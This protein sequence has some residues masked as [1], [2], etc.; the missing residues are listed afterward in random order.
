MVC[1]LNSF[2]VQYEFL[3]QNQGTQ[4]SPVLKNIWFFSLFCLSSAIKFSFF[5]HVFLLPLPVDQDECSAEDHNCNPNADCVNTPGSYRCTCKEGFNGDG[6]SCSGK[7]AETYKINPNWRLSFVHSVFTMHWSARF[8]TWMSVQTTWTCV[9]T[10][11]VWMLL[12]ATAVSVRWASLLQKTARLVKVLHSLCH[13][14]FFSF[15]CSAFIQVVQLTFSLPLSLSLASLEQTS[16]SVISRTSVCLERARTF[17]GC[18]AVCAMT[19]TNWTAAE[20]TALVS[21]AHL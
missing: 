8:Q 17:Q 3:K 13:I 15:C 19:V 20:E 2:T 14:S 18:S 21:V 1:R 4:L 10:A 5:E 9:R 6:F 11:S 7:T 12:V 16:M